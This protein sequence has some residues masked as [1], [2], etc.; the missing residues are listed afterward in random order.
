MS[1]NSFLNMCCLKYD[2]YTHS[3]FIFSFILVLPKF[4]VSVDLPPFGRIMD[5]EFEGQV[6]AK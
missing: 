3:H 4:E 5:K 2:I 1:L 6:T